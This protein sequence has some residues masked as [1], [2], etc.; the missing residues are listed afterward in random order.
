M[1]DLSQIEIEGTSPENDGEFPAEIDAESAAEI[2]REPELEFEP[3]IDDPEPPDSFAAKRRRSLWPWLI[4]AVLLVAAVLAWW[5]WSQ[6]H[7][8]GAEPPPAAAEPTAQSEPPAPEP[9]PPFELPALA[10][11]DE[12]VARLVGA[13]SAHPELTRWL[14][15]EALIERFVAAT[16]NI[17]EGRSP[18]SHFEFAAPKKGFRTVER[19]GEL[20]IDPSSYQR[21]D[22]IAAI[23]RS[24]DTTGSVQLIGQLEPLFD[25]AYA[26]LGYPQGN[27][28]ATLIE[29]ID[30]LLAVPV[31]ET[32]I[33]LKAKITSY[34][35]SDPKLEKLTAAQ[36]HLLRMG[37][38]NIQGIQAKLRELRTALGHAP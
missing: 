18:R 28:R 29:A 33:E 27:F 21:Y 38:N 31:R 5:L 35:F 26:D 32:P 15:H 4:A 7:Q 20:T 23:I 13:L 24:L 11:S 22:T 2:A 30:A 19:G 34:E 3:R 36:K 17:A 6:R 16:D 37:P 25:Q 10:Q 8:Q 1:D 14:A 12:I 9:E